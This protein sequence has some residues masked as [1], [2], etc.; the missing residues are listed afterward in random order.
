MEDSPLYPNPDLIEM[1]LSAAKIS[2]SNNDAEKL[3]VDSSSLLYHAIQLNKMYGLR[4][5]YAQVLNR[6]Y[7][8]MGIY[9][10]NQQLC[11]LENQY[12]SA[13]LSCQDEIN[14]YESTI[15]H[16]VS[17]ILSKLLY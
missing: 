9:G 6:V 8:E 13:I 2:H 12:C 15:S 1:G 5:I 17:S 16:E 3:R 11:E 14:K 7:N 10:Q 4:F